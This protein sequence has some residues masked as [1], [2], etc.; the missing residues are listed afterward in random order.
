MKCEKCGNDYPS[1]YYFATEKICRDCFAKMSVEEKEALKN[2]IL[3]YDSTGLYILRAGFGKRL[4]ATIIDV[5]I[6]SVISLAVLWQTGYFKAVEFF[7]QEVQDAAGD[8]QMI[9]MAMN[10]FFA[11]VKSSLILAQLIP[12]LYFS[13]EI[14]I[15]ASLGKLLLGLRI[16]NEDGTAADKNVLIT[17]YLVKNSSSLLA[18]IGMISGTMFLVSS[19][20]PLVLLVLFIGY[21]FILTQKRQGLHDIVS[22]TA[23]FMKEDIK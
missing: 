18:L 6:Y 17:R 4:A 22:K 11:S 12:L 16:G 5:L 14:M 1:R 15:A 8:A 2:E 23:I 13:L 3:P 20:S 21:F 10:D 9:E 19:V 7:M